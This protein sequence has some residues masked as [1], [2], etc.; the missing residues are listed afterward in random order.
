MDKVMSNRHQAGNISS[1]AMLRISIGCLIVG[2]FVGGLLMQVAG[3]S[4][5]W[6]LVF[7]AVF[8]IAYLPSVLF[9]NKLLRPRSLRD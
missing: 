2:N 6:S 3:V 5:G 1:A 4:K 9:L 8:L 7:M